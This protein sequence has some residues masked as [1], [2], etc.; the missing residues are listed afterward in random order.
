MP[1]GRPVTLV[2]D[3]AD[4]VD[5][6][7][8]EIVRIGIDRAAAGAHGGI[9]AYGDGLDR[10]RFRIVSFDEVA[11]AR[12]NG[13]DL[14]ILDTRRHG[15]WVDSHIDGATHIPL[16]ELLDRMG[17]VPADRDIWVHCASGF[18]A[19]IAASLLA[20]AGRRPVLIDDEYERA[21]KSGLLV[22]TP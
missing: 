4:E 21:S 19:S 17:E 8:R 7:Q 10:S 1:W 12:A 3:T 9:D 22:L 11:E 13:D 15:E 2:G 16:H 20:R 6:A 14:F 18:R 5:R